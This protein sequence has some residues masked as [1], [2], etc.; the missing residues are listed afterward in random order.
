[1]AYHGV[2]GP[3]TKIVAATPIQFGVVVTDRGPVASPVPE[4]TTVADLEDRPHADVFETAA[5]G[6]SG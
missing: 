6:P 5:R 4:R 2:R 3:T 1:M